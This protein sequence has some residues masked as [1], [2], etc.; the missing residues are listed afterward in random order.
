VS[1]FGMNGDVR[2]DSRDGI[3]SGLGAYLLWGA[4]TAYWKLLDEFDAFDLIGWRIVTAMIL[5]L[6]LVAAQKR[7][8]VVAGAL[9]DTRLL[10]RIISAAVLLVVNWTLYVWAVVNEHVIETALGYFIA[11]LFTAMIGVFVL[12]EPLRLLQKVA[13]GFALASVIV[14][15]V[16]YGR[17]PV[18][19][20]AIAASWAFYGLL[21]KQVPLRPVDSLTAETTV[22]TLPALVFVGWSLTRATPV[23][24]ESSA[25]DVALVLLTGLITAVPL[26]LFAHAALRL[27]LTV[28]GPMQYIVPVV[29]FLLGWIVYNEDMQPER[30]VGFVLV[31]IG[32]ACTFTD[33]IRNSDGR[34]SRANDEA[35]AARDS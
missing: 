14:L 16:A 28:I 3:A 8:R 32:L 23:F 24:A 27:P 11:P 26:L 29:N 20:L 9:R 33:T 7:L 21:K 25:L 30:F 10:S 2:R 35:T 31:W 15:T 4:L 22:L 1:N 13:L 17:P 12:R 34:A 6:V 18:V 5:L 19:A